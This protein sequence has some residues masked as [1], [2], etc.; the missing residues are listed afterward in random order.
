MYEMSDPAGMLAWLLQR[1]KKWSD[2]NGDFTVAFP[3]DHILTNATIYWINAAIGQSIRSYRN[4]ER[5]SS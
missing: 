5:P 3:R 2:K 1:W 4:A